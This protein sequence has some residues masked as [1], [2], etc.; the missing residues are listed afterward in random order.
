M[1]YASDS[2][3]L[4]MLEILV[5]VPRATLLQ[6]LLGMKLEV[7]EKFVLR[8]D[9]KS[10]PSDWDSYPFSRKT[11]SI[12]DNWVARCESLA[13]FVPSAVVPVQYNLLINPRHIAARTLRIAERRAV[14]FDSRFANG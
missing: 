8:L 6:P 7:N 5:H 2:L 14:S 13:L 4:A 9:R 10:L 11:Q 1:V 3:S 12:G